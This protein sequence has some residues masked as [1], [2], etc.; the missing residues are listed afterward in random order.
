MDPR[1]D[2][3]AQ[4]LVEYSCE[5]GPGDHV[6]IYASHDAEPL[7]RAL[8]RRIL[9]AGGLPYPFQGYGVYFSYGGY[10]D[11]FFSEASDEQLKHVF[12]TDNMVL[13][14]FQAMIVIRSQTNTRLL[15]GVDAKRQQLRN[16]AY[17]ELHKTY[18]A[19]GAVRELKWVVTLFPND[20]QAQEAEMDRQSYA[21]F[22][23]AACHADQAAAVA[24]WQ[25][26]DRQQAR[27][28]DW[29]KGKKQVH[30]EGP[31]V[32]LR[33]SIDGRTFLN[34]NGKVNMPD[35]EVYTGPVEDS[36]E[37]WIGFTYPAV[38]Y[39]AEVEGVEL[40]FERGRVVQ[41]AASKNQEFLE[42]MLDT[43]E[44]SRRLGEFAVGTNH[45]IDRFTKNILFD[46]KLG[47]TIHLA[48]GSG[49]PETGSVNESA[50]HWDMICDMGP[51]GTITIDDELFYRGGQFLID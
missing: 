27:L 19:R 45:Q 7:V 13:R 25:E 46:E 26:V 50:I 43:D 2:R 42:K 4:I 32:D 22:V 44:G 33:L 28:V 36:V 23:Y 5:V 9:R 38:R 14:E 39:G 34:A 6:A 30:V 41:A 21:D 51:E 24:S 49:Y 11:I 3:L 18:L 20:A 1:V 40:T 35:G 16:Q 10:D 29:L 12:R 47:G 31:T 37:G 48:I 15:S 8:Y 17:S